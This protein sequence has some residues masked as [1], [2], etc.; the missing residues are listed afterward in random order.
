MTEYWRR[1]DATE[2]KLA[3][4]WLR[5]GDLGR[6]DEDGLL[7]LEGRRDDVINRGGEKILPSHLESL[8]SERP[9]VGTCVV[10]GIPH[11]VLQQVPAVALE[12]RPGMDFDVDAA[13]G[14]MAVNLP[15][16]A[17]PAHFLTFDPLPRTASGKIDRLAVRDVIIARLS[18]QA[19]TSGVPQ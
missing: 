16:Y 9:D 5:T 13:R 7:F 11:P 3:G 18:T 19:P 8:L 6:F 15:G 12:V 4:D 2:E 17:I 1:P 14:L 10:I